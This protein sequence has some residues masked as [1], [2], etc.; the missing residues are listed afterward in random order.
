MGESYTQSFLIHRHGAR[1]SIRKPV[2]N[3]IWPS[4]N[5]FWEQNCGKLTPVGV[6]QMHN[7]GLFLQKKYPWVSS[8]NISVYSTRKARALESAWSFVSGLLPETPIKFQHLKDTNICH[9]NVCCDKNMCC[10]RY[11]HKN[12]DH[13]FGIST[14]NDFNKVNI[15]ESEYIQNIS[16]EPVVI[17]LLERLVR[18]NLLPQKSNIIT[19]ILKLKDIASQ[20]QID[21]Q[22]NIPPDA[23]IAG[24]YN[25]SPEEIT[26]INNIANEV[27]YR[28]SAPRSNLVNETIYSLPKALGLITFITDS[29]E[30]WNKFENKLNILSCHDTNLVAFASI[31]GIKLPLPNFAAFFLIERIH[32]TKTG[33]DNIYCYYCSDP[34]IDVILQP[35]ILS[36]INQRE[37]YV[38]WDQLSTGYLSTENFVNN[39]NI[40]L[41][42]YHS[43]T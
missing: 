34:F 39:C 32:N 9:N 2:H 27:I 4:E 31:F 21:N 29:I 37:T 41:E 3:I 15:M 5:Y 35:K 12:K 8:S 1:Y 36:D 18:Q 26:V 23:A 40:I 7:L 24:T 43:V 13:L 11:Y 22:M 30:S 25:L 6:L 16:T 28:R 14:P 20:I 33:T 38:N 10:I 17:N 19:A 42:K